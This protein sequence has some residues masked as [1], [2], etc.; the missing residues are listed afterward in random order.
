MQ[1]G[2]T[3]AIAKRKEAKLVI[4]YQKWLGLKERVLHVAK[5]GRL[6]CDAL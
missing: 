2:K 4:A 1:L 6:N 3:S 5:Y